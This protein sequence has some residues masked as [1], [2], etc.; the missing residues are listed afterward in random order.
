MKPN[1]ILLVDDDISLLFGYRVEMEMEHLL[2]DTATTLAE[3]DDLLNKEKYK[4]VVTDLN[5]AGKESFEGL[6]IVDLAIKKQP[7]STV[8]VV[9][10]ISDDGIKESSLKAGAHFF[11]EK[12]VKACDLIQL[13][14][15]HH[16]D[17]EAGGIRP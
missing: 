3:A 8:I 10:G 7:D 16:S 14:E 17:K 1:R 2:I 9:T 6:I 12:P 15:N 13:F 5:L 4:A 11:L